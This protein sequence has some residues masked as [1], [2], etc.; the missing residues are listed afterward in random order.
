MAYRPF[1]E[2]SAVAKQAAR[3]FKA[4]EVWWS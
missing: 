2:R 1:V 3:S 4:A